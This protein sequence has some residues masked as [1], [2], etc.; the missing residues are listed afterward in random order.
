MV[1]VYNESIYD[2]L[3]SPEEAHE[4]TTDTEERR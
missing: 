2:L 4:E 1:E 3:V